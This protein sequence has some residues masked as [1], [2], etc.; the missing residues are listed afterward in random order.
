MDDDD[1]NYGDDAFIYSQG[2]SM[3][4]SFLNESQPSS[5]SRRTSPRKNQLLTFGTSS[6]IDK[7][8]LSPS[9]N[10]QA[11]I[12]LSESPLLFSQR[13]PSSITGSPIA[14]RKRPPSISGSPVFARRPPSINLDDPTTFS[15]PK[16]LRFNIPENVPFSELD[17]EAFGA[18]QTTKPPPLATIEHEFYG[19]YCLISRSPNRSFKNRCY[20]GYTVDPKRRIKQHNSGQQAGG[21]KKTENRGPWDMVCIVHGFPNS[22]SALRFEWAWQNP[23]KSRRLKEIVLKKTTKESQFAF[24]LRIVCHMLNSDPWRRL[25]LTFRWLIP[26]EEIPFPSDILPPKHMLKK[27]G[28]VEKSTEI[29]PKD[30]DSYQKIQDCFI[31]SEPI[32]SLS[33]FVRCQQMNFCITHF[34]TRCLAELVLKQT[35]EFEVAI[36]PVEG[37][38]LRCHATWKWGDLI[39]DQ[40]KL[41][42]IS[43]VAQDQYRIANATLLIPKPL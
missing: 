27:Y 7:S 35:K 36:V 19:V 4:T 20:I 2:N 38:C 33:Q 30:P 31:C 16:E 24:R 41:I 43:T 8:F 1:F 9:K 3:E 21:A 40:Q 32:A 22:V 12:E 29:V 28:L 25:A 23:D 10:D 15:K 14:G 26:S 37:R 6:Q 11:I 34:H 13:P 39:R 17:D 5:F 18:K 42:Q